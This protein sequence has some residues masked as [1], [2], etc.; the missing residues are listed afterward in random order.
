M[1]DKGIFRS[2][3][4]GFN[5]SDVLNYIDQITAHWESERQSFD[6][7]IRE[8]EEQQAAMAENLRN[9]FAR[10]QEADAACTKVQTEL[11]EALAQLTALSTLKEQFSAETEARQKAEAELAETRQKAEAELTEANQRIAELAEQKDVATREMMAAEDRLSAV[12]EESAS[13]AKTVRE[14]AGQLEAYQQRLTRGE[15]VQRQVDSLVRPYM[16]TASRQTELTLDSVRSSIAAL[17]EQLTTLETSISQQQAALRRANAD[18][19]RA[20]EAHMQAVAAE[21]APAA[22]SADPTA[23]FFR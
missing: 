6:A 15:T 22:P 4:S 16:D 21:T 23:S 17:R 13:L 8:S 2:A 12:Q 11:E 10:A 1:D 9:A 14:Q 18:N 7:R 19:A 5:K 20:M 3:F